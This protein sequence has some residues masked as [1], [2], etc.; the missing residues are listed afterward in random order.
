MKDKEMVSRIAVGHGKGLEGGEL[1]Q[2]GG[3]LNRRQILGKNVDNSLRQIF[4]MKKI[5]KN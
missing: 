5:R 4:M 3:G 2:V 1:Q